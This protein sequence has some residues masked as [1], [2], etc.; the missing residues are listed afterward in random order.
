MVLGCLVLLLCDPD[1]G[2]EV[3]GTFVAKSLG[4]LCE[5]Q[6]S[7][8]TPSSQIFRSCVCP[9]PSS[10]PGWEFTVEILT[11]DATAVMWQASSCLGGAESSEGH[12]SD[13]SRWEA[14]KEER[15]IFQDFFSLAT[16]FF[17]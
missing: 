11:L 8:Y 17:E 16:Y 15:T 10:Y 4:M 13:V 7:S 6:S 14:G 12:H 5:T 9:P 3:K 2:R 1:Q